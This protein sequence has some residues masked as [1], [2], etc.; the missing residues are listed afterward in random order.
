MSETSKLENTLP[1]RATARKQSILTLLRRE[2]FSSTLGLA[3]KFNV[4]EMTIRRDILDLE[5]EGLARR[6][7]GGATAIQN[8]SI[9]PT[10][11]RER[12]HLNFE[13]KA[14]LA[15]EAIKHVA[16]GDI[17]ALDAGSTVFQIARLLASNLNLTVITHSLPALNELATNGH[18]KVYAVGGE[19]HISTQSFSSLDSANIL[20][21][22]RFTTFFLSAGSIRDGAVY[23]ATPYEAV[24]KKAM[25]ESAGKV[26]LVSDSTK[27]TSNALVKVCSLNRIDTLITDNL[28]SDSIFDDLVTTFNI[29][30]VKTAPL[31]TN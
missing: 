1:R 20:S 23:C 9:I 27:F 10:D 30:V 8:G 4:S 18:V 12:N 3:S 28:I 7:H 29:D 25:I 22:F 24:M 11:F 16:R 14:A 17:I 31:P 26:I 2:G 19:L 5:Q 13:R 21:D 15:Q 6:V